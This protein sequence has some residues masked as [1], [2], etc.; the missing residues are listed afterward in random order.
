MRI[1]QTLYAALLLL[2]CRLHAPALRWG[3]S[4]NGI[5]CRLRL[6]VLDT[7][8]CLFYTTRLLAR[9]GFLAL[10]LYFAGFA[11]WLRLLNSQFCYPSCRRSHGQ[12][13][14]AD[15]RG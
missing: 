10:P 2:L 14:M 7:G 5:P 8:A 9:R 6:S 3:S 13:A 15:S 11:R 1:L 12:F 4:P